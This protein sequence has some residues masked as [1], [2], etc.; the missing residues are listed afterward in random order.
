MRAVDFA[1][2]V[3]EIFAAHVVDFF[4]LGASGLDIFRNRVHE[5]VHAAFLV[6][7]R[8]GDQAFVFTAHLVCVRWFDFVVV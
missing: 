1:W 8:Q 3:G 7:C 5:F 6:L 4:N 2:S